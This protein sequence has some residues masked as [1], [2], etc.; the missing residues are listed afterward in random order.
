[1]KKPTLT[2]IIALLAISAHNQNIKV[3]YTYD[4]ASN[5]QGSFSVKK[6]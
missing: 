1:M 6:K 2:I 4:A 5:P 3:E